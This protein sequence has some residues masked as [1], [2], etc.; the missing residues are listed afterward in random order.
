MGQGVFT[1]ISLSSLQES[2]HNFPVISSNPCP[3]VGPFSSL[4]PFTQI[5]PLYSPQLPQDSRSTDH[6]WHCS[7]PWFLPCSAEAWRLGGT[8]LCSH[9]NPSDLTPTRPPPLK[10][11][12]LLL[13]IN[14]STLLL[15]TKHCLR[16]SSPTFAWVLPLGTH[17]Q[18]RHKGRIG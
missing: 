11:F 9:S 12:P 1:N 18:R 4:T 6:G 3:D 16:N 13:F 8:R 2:S 15:D 10:P 14:L 17:I 7:A 5:I